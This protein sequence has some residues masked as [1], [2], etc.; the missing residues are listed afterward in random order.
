MEVTQRRVLMPV[1]GKKGHGPR[2]PKSAVA[3]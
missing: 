3:G 2:A 1:P